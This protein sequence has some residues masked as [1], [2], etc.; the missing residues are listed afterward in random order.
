MKIPHLI[1]V[2]VALAFVPRQLCAI[3]MKVDRITINSPAGGSPVT[4]ATV[5]FQQSFGSVP[6]VFATATN[7]NSQPATVRIRNVTANGFEIG[8]V[9]PPGADGQTAAMTVDYFA[10]ET[11]VY[12]FAGAI[13]VV[14]GSYSTT[15]HQGR[16][17]GGAAW[18]DVNFAITFGSAPAVIAQ[19]QTINSQPALEAG[20]IGNP[21][22]EVA[23]RNVTTVD[24]DVA[25]ERAE[26]STGAVVAETIAYLAMESGAEVTLA[27]ADIKALLTPDSVDGWDNGCD[28]YNY[29]SSFAAAPLVVASQNSRDGG[30][31][32]W[33]RICSVSAT[34]VGLTIDEDQA[35]DSDRSHTTEEAGVL[36]VSAAFHGTQGGRDMEAGSV[37]MA[38]TAAPTNWTSVSFA[39]PFNLVPHIFA[40]PTDQGSAPA[41]IRVRNVTNAGF[42]IAAFEPTGGSASHPQMEIDYV[43]IIP[44]DHTLPSGDVFEVGSIATNLY[45]AGTGGSTGTVNIPF[46]NSN[47]GGSAMLL[48][49][50]SINNELAL[51]PNN[52]SVP[53]LVTATTALGAGSATAA[54]E[55]AEAIAGSVSLPETIAYFAVRDGANDSLDA[56]DGSPVDYE[57]FV[58]PDNILGFAD[59]CYNNNFSDTYATPYAIATQSSR[60][61]NNGGWVRR[62]NLE[63]GR[64]GLTIDED[65]AN[66][67][68]RNHTTEEASVFVFARA[69]EA[70]FNTIDHYAIVHSGSGVTCE[71]ERVTIIAHDA[72]EVGVEAGGRTITV[73]ATSTTPGWSAADA[74]W[75]LA[76]GTGTFSTP[77]AGVAEYVFDTAESSVE[78]WLANTS[79]ADIDIDVVDSDPTLTD[80]DGVAED[81]LLSFS[82][83]GL[84]FYNDADGD[85]DADGSD[86]IASP[87]TA[88]VLSGQLI[89]RGVETNGATGACEG[90]VSGA[91][92]V[93][94]GYE[95]SNPIFCFR[96]DDVHINGTPIQD[97][98]AGSGPAYNPVSLIFD[99]DGEAPFTM[100]YFDAGTLRLHAQLFVPAGGGNPA[101]TLTGASDETIVRPAD[102]VIT[103]IT[104]SGG[105]A[106]PATTSAGGGFVAADTPFTVVVEARNADGG[107]TPNFGGEIVN[108]GIT[109]TPVSLVMPRTGNLP[110]LSSAATFSGTGT[111]GELQNTTVRWAE[112]GTLTLR[113]EI[114]D[115]DYLGTGNVIGAT[116]GNVGRFYADHLRLVSS[117]VANGCSGGFTYMSDQAFSYTPIDVSYSVEAVTA[118][119][120]RL[121]NYD[122]TFPVATLTVGAENA[123]AGVNLAGRIAVP[124]GAWADG[125]YAVSGTDNAGF[126]RALSGLDEVPDGPYGSTQLGIRSAGVD[127]DAT[128]F[129]TSALN[130]NAATN[131]D[132]ALAGTCDAVS[133]GSALDIR[134]GRLL[135]NNA[136]GPET[137]PLAVP[138]E[139]Q[140][141]DAVNG[142]LINSADSCTVLAMADIR[143]DGN[144]L[145]VDANRTVTVGA[146]ASTGSFG[147]FTPGVGLSF[148]AGDA[149]L[150]FSAPGAGNNG[151]FNVDVDLSNYP[152][153]RSDWDNDGNAA[154]DSVLPSAQIRFGRYRGHD[155]VIYWH[156]V[157]D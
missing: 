84:R 94:M 8:V 26:T 95:C 77:S 59:G 144:P 137:A 51:D 73:T 71:A 63:A 113:A 153:L 68:E 130:M 53:W 69:F 18:D 7:S 105:A 12:N 31:G 96:E 115:G 97:N 82:N 32:G 85:G 108:E 33:A 148:S 13:R 145:A 67:A 118:G 21:F 98:D 124:S 27:G 66:D 79:E 14:V 104:D 17:V 86:P 23:I 125:L 57:M 128:N 44:G 60:D 64:I 123:N 89:L 9:E 78:L 99:A 155:R 52:I 81:P 120:S 54:L 135:I 50:Q 134:F 39:N 107:V 151:E 142:F 6:V 42:D 20:V 154:D 61:G 35:A 147:S 58:T 15:T 47:S 49:V 141:W 19:V 41:A 103:S 110:A 138:F 132:C 30:D 22:L 121:Q 70:E 129:Q 127:P 28:V 152:W 119:L 37:T 1:V 133:L 38:G 140:S 24:M 112:V 101:V 117:S 5:N 40:L 156:E 76:S 150:N 2:A 109:L 122:D 45:L 65:Q 149:G 116:S 100:E 102:F 143:F 111:A 43:A 29:S 56:S 62:C 34:G 55:R 16:N 11:G 72:S 126:A 139:T 10:A 3:D 46:N 25:L 4:W 106:N 93:S 114:R 75:T 92:T 146:G 83:T 157:L 91:Q 136:H 36:A 88:G 74:T 90:R 131:D 87:L 80:Q 48:Q